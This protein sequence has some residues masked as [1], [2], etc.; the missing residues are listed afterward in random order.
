[1][2]QQAAE[3]GL[4]PEDY[5]ASVW[6]ARLSALNDTSAGSARVRFDA[7]MATK[8][9]RYSRALSVGRLNPNNLG[10]D[11]NVTGSAI[12]LAIVFTMEL[13]QS[14]QIIDARQG[15]QQGVDDQEIRERLC[16]ALC[17][18]K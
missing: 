6:G 10:Q 17:R 12:P 4:E 9:I 8:L 5:V 18:R 14:R 2:F 7:A 3:K 15:W 1:M 13:P 11:I 16:F